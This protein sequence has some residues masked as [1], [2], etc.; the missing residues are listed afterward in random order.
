MWACSL[1]QEATEAAMSNDG[2]VVLS[3]RDSMLRRLLAVIDEPHVR[4]YFY[5]PII[6]RAGQELASIGVMMMFVQALHDYRE[7]VAHESSL[8]HQLVFR[9]DDLVDALVPD[10]EAA[11]ELKPGV[12]AAMRA[13]HMFGERAIV[14]PDNPTLMSRLGRVD[15]DVHLIV[16]FHNQ[17]L[18]K[19]A[20][21]RMS[22]REVKR[23]LLTAIENYRA[24]DHAER[25]HVARILR[26]RFERYIEALVEDNWLLEVTLRVEEFH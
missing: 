21:K 18:L 7:S 1:F 8:E 12:S 20:G 13:E 23:S 16:H 26:L 14:I 5:A 22:P 17:Q 24:V 19:L 25:M 11:R 15:T 3:D 2:V 4:E 10:E 9:T 6:R